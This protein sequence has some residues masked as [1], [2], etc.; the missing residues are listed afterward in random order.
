M[1]FL[2]HVISE[3]G[4]LVDPAKIAT[5]VHWP[6]PTNVSEVQSFLGMAAYYLRFVKDFTKIA[7]P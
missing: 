7:I 6:R 4:N 2:G 5:I 1:H 3:K